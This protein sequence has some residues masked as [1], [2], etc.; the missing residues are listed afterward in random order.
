MAIAT[1][2]SRTQV[3]ALVEVSLNERV[4]LQ[5]HTWYT[6]PTGKK[7]IITGRAQCTSRGAA[8]NTSLQ[9]SGVTMF[10]YDSAGAKE[11]FSD[12]LGWEFTPRHLTTALSGE[13]CFFTDIEL[14][15]GQTMITVQNSGTNAAWNVWAN[16]KELP[17]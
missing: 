3:S 11:S 6:C 5:P 4:V 1:L 12:L 2:T 17:A 9:F 7:A 14:A 16:V 10:T 13:F 15:A 8:A